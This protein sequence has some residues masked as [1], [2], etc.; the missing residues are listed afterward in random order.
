M[1]AARP[2]DKHDLAQVLEGLFPSFAE[3]RGKLGGRSVDGA[4]A[5]KDKRIF[6]PRF[7]RQYFL[8]KVPSELFSQKEFNAF[9]SPIRSATEDE[10]KRKTSE[11]VRSLEQEDFKR[12]H[13][14]HRIETV[15]EGFNATTKRGL[16]RG[17][18][19]NSQ[20]WSS[21]AF[22]FFDA[23][24]CIR[25]AL[26]DMKDSSDR[27]A[28]LMIV[29]A[30]STS[31][32]CALLMVEMLQKEAP[33]VMPP[34]HRPIEM[35]LAEKMRRHYLDS[36]APSIFEEFSAD[37]GKIEPIQLLFGWR[38]L[39]PDAAQDQERYLVDLFARRPADMNG[40][41]KS[42]FRIEFM[43]DYTALKPLI[44]YDRLAELIDRNAEILDQSKVQDFRNRY[45][46]ERQ[47]SHNESDD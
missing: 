16:C 31:T 27:Q 10:V 28:F 21:D 20:L 30:E 41:L 37:A 4:T 18:V 39:G 5:E 12:W 32:L 29:T 6:H 19:A 47:K 38:R 43:D 8:L 7:F 46:A 25:M 23:V 2:G 35:A 15:F 33:E 1:I 45:A 44:N 11:M 14:V 17:L 34:D 13:F 24:R 36:G 3:Y 42:M 26:S 9:Q 40:L 22:E